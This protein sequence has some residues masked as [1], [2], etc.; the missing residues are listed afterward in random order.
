M[1]KM[2]ADYSEVVENTKSSSR[3]FE[4]VD[5]TFASPPISE[6]VKKYGTEHDP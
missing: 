2:A 5:F 1:F 4:H 3:H 6:Y